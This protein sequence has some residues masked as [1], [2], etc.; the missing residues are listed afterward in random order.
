MP[1]PLCVSAC[2]CVDLPDVIPLHAWGGPEAQSR[3]TGIAKRVGGIGNIM[4]VLVQELA[5]GEG[6]DITTQV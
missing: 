5:R 4:P 1:Q 2:N 6:V 3:R